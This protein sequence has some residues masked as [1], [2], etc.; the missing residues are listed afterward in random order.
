MTRAPL[1]LL[2]AAAAS[3]HAA[4]EAQ[5]TITAVTV[6]PDEAMVTREATV[7]LPSAGEQTISFDRLSGLLVDSSVQIS[8]SGDAAAGIESV[9]VSRQAVKAQIAPFLNEINRKIEQ[10]T[11]REQALSDQQKELSTKA[12]ILQ[13]L[14]SAAIPV[15]TKDTPAVDY[16]NVA[17]LSTYVAEQQAAI[18]TENRRLASQLRAVN[19]EL[20]TAQKQRDQLAPAGDVITTSVGLRL[21]AAAAGVQHL[22]LRYVVR[23]A[24]WMPRYDARASTADNQV[25]LSYSGSVRQKTGESWN[26]VRLTLSTAQPA[27]GNGPAMLEPW[28]ISSVPRPNPSESVLGSEVVSLSPFEVRAAGR[29]KSR[30]TALPATLHEEATNASFEIKADASVGSDNEPETEPIA[31]LIFDAVPSYAATPK[32]IPAAFLTMHV[33][34]HSDFPLLAGEVHLFVDQ[35]FVAKGTLTTVLPGDGLDLSFGADQK[36]T[37]KRKLVRR[38]RDTSGLLAQRKRTAYEY[39]LEFENH[40]TVPVNLTVADQVPLSGDSKI[41]VKLL[42]P[43][44][45]AMKPDADGVFHWKLTLAP[46]EKRTLPLKFTVEAPADLAVYGLGSVDE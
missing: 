37:A 13:Q 29:P 5:S 2:L 42:A 39:A 38:Y 1:F 41:L 25:H 40:K 33:T 4:I 3:A 18:D 35:S 10:L 46:G 27:L 14:V 26:A 22:L 11:D 6:Y 21:Q 43:T 34:N 32:E 31:D 24:G 45:P 16:N 12:N 20:Q 30:V 19:A 9:T 17:K 7:N 23:G 15:A 28:R 36:V 8:G 44:D